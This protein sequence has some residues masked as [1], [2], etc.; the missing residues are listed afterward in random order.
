MGV[1]DNATMV[2]INNKE[3]ESIKTNAGGIIYQRPVSITVTGDSIQLGYSTNQWLGTIGDVVIDCGDGTQSTVN[4]PTTELT[5]TYTDGEQSHSIIFLGT[6]TSLG[7]YCFYNCTGLTSVT[8]PNSVTSLGYAC[9]YYCT[10]LTSVTIPSSVTSIGISCFA[11]CTRLTS[12]TIPNS[13]T[14]I[15]DACFY[16]CTGLTSITI[17]NSVTSLGNYCF[18]DCNSLINYQL[19]WTGNN[20]ITYNSETMPNY[21]NTKFYVPKGQKTNYVNK[22]Y[23][24]TKVVERSS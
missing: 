7:E 1:F 22:S 23:P 20:I 3:V 8:I 9:F 17:P 5:H 6:V 2:K 19:Y 11:Y 4:N 16:R 21:T 12:V 13:V 15:G 14:S 24:S 18:M 10:G